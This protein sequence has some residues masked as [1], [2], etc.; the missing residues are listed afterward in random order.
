MQILE[1]FTL[2]ISERMGFSWIGLLKDALKCNGRN[3]IV[4]IRT[5]GM[6]S[7]RKGKA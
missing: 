7:S 5:R 2:L 6:E 1:H 3:V 4:Y